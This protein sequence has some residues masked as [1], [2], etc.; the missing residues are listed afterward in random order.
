MTTNLV[1]LGLGLLMTSCLLRIGDP[2][3]VTLAEYHN[4]ADQS[5]MVYP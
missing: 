4:A 5:V 1:V 2:A 3:P